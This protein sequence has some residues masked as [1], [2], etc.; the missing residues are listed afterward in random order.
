MPEEAARDQSRSA[1]LNP[2]NEDRPVDRDPVDRWKAPAQRA[3]PP[4]P[5]VQAGGT[6]QHRA[7]IGRVAATGARKEVGQAG[8]EGSHQP[9]VVRY[10]VSANPDAS[11]RIANLAERLTYLVEHRRVLDR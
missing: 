2:E 4:I 11:V 9:I 10:S 5:L 6:N 1:G 8:P 3:P 7:Q